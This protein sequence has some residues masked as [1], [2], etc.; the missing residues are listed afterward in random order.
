LFGNGRTH[1]LP[2]HRRE[3]VL[4][5]NLPHHLRYQSRIRFVS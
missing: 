2:R 4:F 1:W 3:F 5:R